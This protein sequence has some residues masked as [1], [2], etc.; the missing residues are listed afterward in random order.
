MHYNSK[1][2]KLKKKKSQPTDPIIFSYV[3]GN[4]HIFLFGLMEIRTFEDDQKTS[5]VHSHT[6]SGAA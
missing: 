5:D 2:K 6:R 1:K 3:T 4:K